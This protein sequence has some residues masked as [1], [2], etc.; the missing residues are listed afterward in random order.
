MPATAPSHDVTILGGGLAGLT[1]A[2]Q[3]Q[4]SV[5]TARILI[6][7]RREFPVPE[8]AFKVGE[9]TI[10][11]GAHY[12]AEVAG[13]K[14]HL[15]EDQL[16][17][18]G[19]RFFFNSGHES[20]ARG[21][22]VG[23]SEFFP[24]PGY[25]V[26]R[27]RLENFLGQDVVAGGA[28]L[29]ERAQVKDIQLA[30]KGHAH[31]VTYLR[32]EAEQTIE[33]RWV[34][35][36]SGRAALLKRQLDLA[37]DIGHDVNAVWF[38]LGS[39]IRVDQWCD[40]HEWQCR[41]GR[42][43]QRWLSTNHFLGRGYWI[44]IIPL[45]CGATSIGI[46]ADPRLHEL[47]EMKSFDLALDWLQR[48]EPLCAAAIEAERDQL[49]DFRALKNIG[50]GCRE[51]YS[52]DRWAITGEAGVFLDPLYSPGIDYIA[53]ANTQICSLI[54]H[55]LRGEPLELLA[56]RYQGIFLALFRDN[57]QTY[58]DQYPL[59]GNPRIMSLKYVWDYALYW[60]FPAL[61]YFNGK[62]TDPAFF[63]EMCPGI[64]KLRELNKTIQRFFREWHAVEHDS[65]LPAVFVDQNE[66]AILKRL[67]GELKDR[68][69]DAALRKRFKQNVKSL[70]ALAAEI[71]SRITRTRPAL[72]SYQ[73][74]VPPGQERL[75]EVF[76]ELQL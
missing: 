64:E 35:D 55:D 41:A 75:T 76:N 18:F 25:Q 13:L 61:L 19:L 11:V 17:K 45:A 9:S 15:V 67:N 71:M 29:V 47:S 16:P 40:D 60:S 57:L 30:D 70:E 48:H 36:A 59:L 2:N 56:P 6:L 5:P 10:E 24:S 20:L 27:G 69:D 58:Q 7:E 51:V 54:E 43:Q 73:P 44:W 34:V 28:T 37:E 12:L 63:S 49:H 8:G 74:Q 46:V 38:R 39:D 53:I 21:V 66:I 14:K 32:D 50:L 42:R 68:L 65:E 52:A 62:M 1:L 22:E 72:M 31:R 4:Q 26:D 23:L 33:T 3:L